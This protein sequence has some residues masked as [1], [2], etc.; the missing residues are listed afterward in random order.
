MRLFKVL[1]WPEEYAWDRPCNLGELIDWDRVAER[2]Y[3]VVVIPELSCE[4]TCASF[5]EVESVAR[6]SAMMS[7]EWNSGITGLLEGGEFALDVEKLV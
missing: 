5:D 4:T 6:S 1:C 3:W 7:A 2:G